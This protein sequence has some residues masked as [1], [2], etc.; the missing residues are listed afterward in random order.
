MSDMVKLVGP[1]GVEGEFPEVARDALLTAGYTLPVVPP[2]RENTILVASEGAEVD[3][4]LLSAEA[5]Q[6]MLRGGFSWKVADADVGPAEPA[7]DDEVV[8][9]IQGTLATMKYGM[10]KGLIQAGT[11]KLVTG[12]TDDPP[13]GAPAFKWPSDDAMVEIKLA[14]LPAAIPMTFKDARPI[15]VAGQGQ[16]V[17]D[18]ELQ[19]RILENE[20]KRDDKAV[21]Q[22]AASGA[23]AMDPPEAAA[24]AGNSLDKALTEG[25]NEAGEFTH[26]A[27]PGKSYK[28]KGAVTQALNRLATAGPSGADGASSPGASAPSP[29][30]VAGPPA[31]GK[32]AKLEQ[33]KKLIASTK[34]LMDDFEKLLSIF[35]E[36]AGKRNVGEFTEPELDKLIQRLGTEASGI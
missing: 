33:A 25:P 19:V 27:I 11:A 23:E 36:V 1:D 5:V 22:E 4:A 3:A 30:P 28:T 9:D 21:A 20:D 35:E 10:A 8:I 24:V 16:I 32:E 17:G 12:D 14:A 18:D 15:V 13:A 31:E 6:V 26:P 7:D 29:A 2:Q 34:G